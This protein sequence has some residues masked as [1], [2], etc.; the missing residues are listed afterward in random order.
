QISS[1]LRSYLLVLCVF[2]GSSITSFY[3]FSLHDALPISAI[4]ISGCQ[5]LSVGVLH[6]ERVNTVS[7]YS[8][9]IEFSGVSGHID[10]ISAYYIRSEEHTSELQSRFELVCRLLLEKKNINRN[11]SIQPFI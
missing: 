4:A 5:N 7:P 2:Y 11:K 9:C 8:G 10:S 1:W 3:S 6:I